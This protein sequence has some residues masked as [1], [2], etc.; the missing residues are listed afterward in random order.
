MAKLIQM[1]MDKG[2]VLI[3]VTEDRDESK[4][5][6]YYKD[7]SRGEISNI[8]KKID[9]AFDTVIQD[10]IIN[11]CKILV[12]AFEKLKQQTFPPKKAQA[13]FGLQFNAEGNVY[14]TKIGA[15]AS[16]NISFEWEF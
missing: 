3:E 12:G 14:I 16:F 1:K 4:N 11:H 15:E 7:T 13:E 6:D 9:Q 10:Q 5:D 2:T 8:I